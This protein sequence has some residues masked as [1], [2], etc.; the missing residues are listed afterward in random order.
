M[1]SVLTQTIARLLLLPTL[2]TAI[3]VLIKGYVAVGDGFAAGVIAAMALLLQY[4]AFS[5]QEVEQRLPLVRLARP[6]A[7]AG[8]LLVLLVA[9][10]PLLAGDEIVTHYPGPDQKVA[11][12]GT[13]EL[14]TVVL[15]DT[16]VF[17][18]VFGF[19]VAIVRLVAQVREQ[20]GH[21]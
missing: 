8:L 10:A 15:F 5:R 17:C 2:V 21:Q 12:L 14:H 6:L 20:E 3:A 19:S 16:G 9:F 4:V 11:H 7:L 18:L 13:L 1:T